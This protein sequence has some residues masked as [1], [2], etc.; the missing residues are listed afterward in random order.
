MVIIRK[1]SITLVFITFASFTLVGILVAASFGWP[2]VKITELKGQD[3]LIYFA[4]MASIFVTSLGG[5]TL[6]YLIVL[7]QRGHLGNN[8]VASTP[9]N[10]PT[11]SSDFSAEEEMVFQ[12]LELER[13]KVILLNL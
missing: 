5:S 12:R 6:I 9:E 13:L 8:Q 7:R 3:R 1:I 2:K 4:C 10:H 11:E